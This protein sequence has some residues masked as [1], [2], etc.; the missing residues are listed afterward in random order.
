MFMKKL[1]VLVFITAL[2]V[3]N[4]DKNKRYSKRVD[5]NKW[6][7]TELTIDGE[8]QD[9]LPVIKFN[10]CDIYEETCE[11][12]WSSSDGKAIIAWQFRDKGK[13]FELSNQ[14]DHGHDLA[15]IKA[16]QQCIKFTG[17]YEVIKSKLSRFEIKSSKTI[18]Y[19][20]K[21][22]VITMEKQ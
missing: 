15:D 1:I 5:D 4:C 12:S 14:T 18:G 20:N 7:V 8:K 11:G 22:V 13:T 6:E 10:F 19:P 17:I 16:A 9:S 3:A 21:S 2:I